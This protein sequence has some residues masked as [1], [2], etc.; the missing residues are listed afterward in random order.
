MSESTRPPR[1]RTPQSKAFQDYM[2]TGWARPE[3]A[4]PTTRPVAEYAAA[5]RARLLGGLPESLRGKTLLIPAGPAVRRANDTDYPYRPHSAFVYLTGWG[6]E[7]TPGSLLVMDTETTDTT[8]YLRGPAPRDSD[9]F[10]ANPAIGEFWTGPRASVADVGQELGL[11]TKDLSQWSGISD[12][13]LPHTVILPDADDVLS[14]DTGHRRMALGTA[15]DLQ[16]ADRELARVLSE[17]R[18]VKDEYEI[19]E[20]REAIASTH[21]GFDDIVRALPGATEVARGER[22]IEGV[23]AARA[24]LEGNDVGYGTIA[25]AGSHACTLHW[26][27]NHGDIHSGELLL[28][29]AGVERESLYTADITRTFPVSGVFSDTQREV[30]DAVLEAA[31]AALAAVKPGVSFRTLHDEAMRVIARHTASWGLLPGTADESLSPEAGWHRRFMIHGTG[32]HLG[33]DVH[34]CQQAR[35][36]VYQ[37]Q[38][39]QPGMVFTIEP[40]LYFQPDDLSVPDHLRGIGIRIEDN[41]LV[42]KTGAEVLSAAIPRTASEV[43]AWMSAAHHTGD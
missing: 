35:R 23:F 28:V 2:T 39:L 34:D 33:L 7:T 13:D 30:Y 8:V 25:A 22:V 43:E 12:Q 37:D 36:E 20:L 29:D 14:W 31:D 6:S 21:R 15:E 19:A 11:E 32:H 4:A 17:D 24:R 27:S 9:E 1:S 40:G 41:I 10:Y 16:E 42:T 5:R 38:E 3:G 18:F 26:V